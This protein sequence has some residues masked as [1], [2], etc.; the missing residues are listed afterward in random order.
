MAPEPEH[1]DHSWTNEAA[2]AAGFQK[3]TPAGADAALRASDLYFARQMQDPRLM[4]DGTRLMDIWSEEQRQQFAR[5]R[6]EAWAQ[7][8]AERAEQENSD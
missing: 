4:M 8:A 6:P 3:L 1:V 5:D 7:A 2:K